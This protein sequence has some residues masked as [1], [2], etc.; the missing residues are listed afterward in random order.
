MTDQEGGRKLDAT[1]THTYNFSME[2]LTTTPRLDQQ[3]LQTTEPSLIGSDGVNT[4]NRAFEGQAHALEEA[5]EEARYWRK[6]QLRV[7]S[8]LDE[9]LAM[10]E[11]KL[12]DME[13]QLLEERSQRHARD[14]HG[15]FIPTNEEMSRGHV[16]PMPD[17]GHLNQSC[18]K[19]QVS[20]TFASPS[21]TSGSNLLP[22]S[23]MMF[24]GA[25]SKQ[26][27]VTQS[28]TQPGVN[29][30]QGA[31]L[32]SHQYQVNT[33]QSQYII[34]QQ[35]SQRYEGYRSE[36][37]GAR[38]NGTYGVYSNGAQGFGNHSGAHTTLYNNGGQQAYN[39]VPCNEAQSDYYS[40]GVM[41]NEQ[42]HPRFDSTFNTP[43]TPGSLGANPFGSGPPRQQAF[44]PYYKPNKLND[45]YGDPQ[46]WP[47]WINQY[48]ATSA[49]GRFSDLDNSIRLRE[50]LKGPA[51]MM[52]K[53]MLMLPSNVNRALAKLEEN[54]GQAH[55]VIGDVLNQLEDAPS[56]RDD[57]P[58][59]I[60]AFSALV[61]NAVA[62]VEGMGRLER[63]A[64]PTLLAHLV[65][66]LPPMQKMNWGGHAYFG[67]TLKDFSIWL[68]G[69]A[70]AAIK[71]MD[72]PVTSAALGLNKY[73][74]YGPRRQWNDRE[75]KS[76]GVHVHTGFNDESPERTLSGGCRCCD[77]RGHSLDECKKFKMLTVK[78]RWTLLRN[79]KKGMKPVCYACLEPGHTANSCSTQSSCPVK[80]CTYNHNQLLHAS[81]EKKSFKN[82]SKSRDNANEHPEPHFHTTSCDTDVLFKITA[83]RLFADNGKSV[84]VLA[85]ID[86]GS[87]VTLMNDSVRKS[88]GV[89][90]T[91]APLCLSWTGDTTRTEKNSRRLTLGIQ[92]IGPNCKRFPLPDVRT[93]EDLDLPAQSLS[94]SDLRHRYP[95]LAKIPFVNYPDKQPQILIG[96]IHHRLGLTTDTVEGPTWNSPSAVETRLGWIICGPVQHARKVNKNRVF[97]HR[98]ARE[99]CGCDMDE[100]LHE[101]FKQFMTTEAFGTTSSTS[102]LES[103]EDRRTREIVEGTTRRVGGKRY[104]T[105][106]LWKEC[107]INLPNSFGMALKRL[108]C[109]ESRMLKDSEYAR[110][111]NEKIVEYLDKA[112]VRKLS[113]KEVEE[114][115]GPRHWITPHSGIYNINK[116]PPKFRLIF[117]LAAKVNGVSLNAMLLK[118][119]DI[120]TTIVGVLYRGRQHAILVIGDIEEMFLRVK[121]RKEDQAALCFLWRNGNSGRSP[122]MYA[123][124]VLPF[125]STCSPYLA[126]KVKNM[127]AADY[128]KTHPRAVAAI[129]HD[130]YVD[131]LFTSFKTEDEAIQITS[132]IVNI[133]AEGGFKLRGFL[134][135]SRRVTNEL[136]GTPTSSKETT[137]INLDKNDSDKVLGLWWRA[138]DD[139]ITFKFK[140]NKVEPDILS[141]KIR[142]TKRI[143][144]RIVMSIYDPLGLIA[145]YMSYAKVL[146]QYVWRVGTGWDQTIDDVAWKKW[147]LW[148]N[149]LQSAEKIA[150]PRCYSTKIP[151]ATSIQLHIFVDASDALFA[152]VG[153]LRV[154]DSEGVVDVALVGAKTRVAP[155]KMLSIPRLELQ[156]AVLGVRQATSMLS[157]HRIFVDKVCFWSD[158]ETVLGWLRCENVRRYKQFVAFRVSE[159]LDSTSVTDWRWIGTNDNVADDAT[160]WRK[161]PTFDCNDRWFKGP[162]FLRQPEQ[163]WPQRTKI[164][165]IADR[166]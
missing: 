64:D 77:Y 88:L 66:K 10:A 92:G 105:G 3:N 106:L 151:N 158:S 125:G 121:V 70:S 74:E 56:P 95:H 131:D 25:I 44:V 53:G 52:V 104:E 51:L 50:S 17:D 159:V 94:M 128:E 76:A 142:P 69:T 78:E 101:Q 33:D 112:Y 57:R 60:V 19:P 126:Q 165:W 116:N 34:N 11:K 72:R 14:D 32:Q 127:N 62:V 123:I 26:M 93:V 141:G 110:V 37:Y 22:P 139:T 97:A 18:R 4:V 61:D 15:K 58:E 148:W 150:I 118:G 80:G 161:V 87:S 145:H 65:R 84:E 129:V 119:P 146:L 109:T 86:E 47:E 83:V 102:S 147:K 41:D 85:F 30:V 89:E 132:E 163:Q 46:H 6:Q 67:S 140:V 113:K 9:A 43:P 28:T 160:K 154:E 162:D 81:E 29:N 8:E 48:H 59:S 137:E 20:V 153:Y 7:R 108:I 100:S 134:S 120:Y 164:T 68:Q 24:T 55:F 82:K 21:S 136:N 122:D 36:P 96:L 98:I 45:F 114:V 111:Y 42:F 149:N 49:A 138:Q 13:R 135:N 117:D 54:F 2:D 133:H 115:N 16:V 1:P 157:E 152:A 99:L 31:L 40:K 155:L 90:G 71:I 23:N 79:V 124:T 12:K 144:L 166:Y 35:N 143:C 156:A 75:R 107:D 5:R 39:H 27:N 63:L 91:P 73:Q 38:C 103:S 130:H